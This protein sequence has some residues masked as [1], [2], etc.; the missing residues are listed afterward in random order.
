ML[1]M[2]FRH[3]AE[4]PRAGVGGIIFGGVGGDAEHLG[5]LLH[6]QAD[7]V[8]QLDQFSLPW[9]LGGQFV[10]GFIDGQDWI[11]DLLASPIR[12]SD[13]RMTTLM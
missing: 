1:T 9:M 11:P 5:G 8:S 12:K 2:R 4:Q 7:E 10:E 3:L 6:R 13:G